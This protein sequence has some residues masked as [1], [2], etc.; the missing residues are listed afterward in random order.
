[1]VNA[2]EENIKMRLPCLI[3]TLPWPEC[4]QNPYNLH[5][6]YN[7]YPRGATGYN[8]FQVGKC[9]II[10]V[11]ALNLFI[12]HSHVCTSKCTHTH[13]HKHNG[14][15]LTDGYGLLHSSLSPNTGNTKPEQC[16]STFLVMWPHIPWSTLLCYYHV[17][18]GQNIHKK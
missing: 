8:T 13:T 1:M 11:H 16:L 15:M 12:M 2:R 14:M 4:N 3:Y 6:R 7:M 18:R 5:L 17:E 9:P 10:H